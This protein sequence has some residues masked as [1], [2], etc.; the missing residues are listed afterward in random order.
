LLAKISELVISTHTD[1]EV[2]GVEDN[3]LQVRIKGDPDIK[4]LGPFSTFVIA[5]GYES[6]HF[7]AQELEKEN[8]PFTVHPVG[9]CVSPRNALHAISEGYNVAHSL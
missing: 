8:I 4:D 7:L 9:D 6:S 2:V 5:I 3:R 1:C